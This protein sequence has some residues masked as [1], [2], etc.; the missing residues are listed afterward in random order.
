MK[1][2]NFSFDFR[3]SSLNNWEKPWEKTTKR[4]SDNSIFSIFFLF[5]VFFYFFFFYNDR[6]LAVFD[7]TLLCWTILWQT[8]RT[9]LFSPPKKC[10]IK[11][12]QMQLVPFSVLY[13]IIVHGSNL[14]I[15]NCPGEPENFWKNFGALGRPFFGFSLYI[16]MNIYI[17]NGFIIF[18]FVFLL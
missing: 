8:E 10:R 7:L 9:F 18:E 5:V 17:N 11:T 2:I 6:G 12:Q 16:L 13:I 1:G 14:T 4:Y 3:C 15:R